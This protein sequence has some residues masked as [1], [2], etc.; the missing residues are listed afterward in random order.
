MANSTQNKTAVK[1]GL[2]GSA[3]AKKII[4]EIGRPV[5]TIAIALLI[6]ALIILLMGEDPIFA[7]TML[8]SGAFKGL[9]N[10]IATLQNTTPLLFTGLAVSFAFR[11]NVTNIGVEGQMLF[12]A[13]AAGIVGY[14]V[15]LPWF[16]HIPLAIIAAGLA[17][18]LW[19]Y[20]P[21]IMKAKLNVNEMV[22]CLMLNPIALL[23]TGY[24]SSYPLK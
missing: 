1:P 22:V 3:T 15:H 19:A 4:I 11:S 20:I 21:A 2:S 5:V 6:G 10:I 18:A 24:L 16:L 14:Y 12:G 17:G 13:L 9:G 23:I 8:F 7:Y